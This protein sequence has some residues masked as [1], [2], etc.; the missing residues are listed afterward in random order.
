MRE[1]GTKVNITDKE[2]ILLHLMQNILGLGCMENITVSALLNGLTDLFTKVNGRIVAKTEMESSLALTERYT[3]VPGKMASI[4]VKD[5]WVLQ[6]EV[7]IE[8]HLNK[9]SSCLKKSI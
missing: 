7:C 5:N 8:A 2:R 9:V 6:T 1:I 4:T 3:K